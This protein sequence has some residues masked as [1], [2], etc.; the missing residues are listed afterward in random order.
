MAMGIAGSLDEATRRATTALAGWLAADHGLSPNDVA[1]VMGT[2]VEYDVAELVS[3]QFNV[4]ARISK[5]SI[6]QP[7]AR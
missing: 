3:P 5:A 7:T 4:V 1:L 6:R 2:A